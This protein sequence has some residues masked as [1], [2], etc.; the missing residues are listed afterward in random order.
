GIY[1]NVETVKSHMLQHWF[2][3]ADGSLFEATDVDFR[4]EF[5]ETY[6]IQDGP[7]DRTLLEQLATAL[8]IASPDLAMAAAAE[9]VD[10]DAFL[11]FWATCAVIAQFD[12]FPYSDP[13]DDY[14]V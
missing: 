10:M 5:I 9:V 2:E 13:G 12:S 14:F 8:Q 11:Q 1:A 7:G 4:P 3:D 6:E